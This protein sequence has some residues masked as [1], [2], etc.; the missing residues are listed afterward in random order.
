MITA[1]S[2]LELSNIFI[3]IVVYHQG[4]AK[5]VK[6]FALLLQIFTLFTLRFC[7][8]LVCEYLALFYVIG[9]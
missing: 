4:G 8:I 3:D 1:L 2:D 9:L 6:N 7:Y 5:L